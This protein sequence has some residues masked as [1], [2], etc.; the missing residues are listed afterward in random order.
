MRLRKALGVLHRIRH[1]VPE[2]IMLQLYDSLIMPHV[3]Y[4]ISAYGGT[5]N[6]HLK[7]ILTMQKKGIRCVTNSP[8]NS[9]CNPLFVKHKLLNVYDMYELSCL[10]LAYRYIRDGLPS[11]HKKEL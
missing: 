2:Y 9:H 4:A 3:N 6:C 8:Y 11:Y 7:R 1:Q 10:K 5:D